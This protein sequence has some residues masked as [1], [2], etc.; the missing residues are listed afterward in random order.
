LSMRLTDQRVAASR[1]MKIE[2]IVR[3]G[4]PRGECT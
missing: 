2:G 4:A 1:M 3:A